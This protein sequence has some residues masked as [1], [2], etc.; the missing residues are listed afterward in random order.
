MALY[1]TKDDDG[2]Y[3]LF[4]LLLYS[5]GISIVYD[6]SHFIYTVVKIEYLE[7]HGLSQSI[8]NEISKTCNFKKPITK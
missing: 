8:R 7:K 2:I 6:N 1:S 4:F 3:S 5:F